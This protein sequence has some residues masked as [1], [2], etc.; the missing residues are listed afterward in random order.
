[1]IRTKNKRKIPKLPSGLMGGHMPDPPDEC[2][3]TRIDVLVTEHNRKY[4]NTIFCR[5]CKNEKTCPRR[6]EFVQEWKAYR[7]WLKG[8]E[9]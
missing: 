5:D 3:A 8:E 1:M 6:Q 9:R 7:A 4:V 2:L